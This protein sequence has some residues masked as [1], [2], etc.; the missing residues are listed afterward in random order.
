VAGATAIEAV[1][2]VAGQRRRAAMPNATC[3]ICRT[4]P[5]G[6]HADLSHWAGHHI[7]GVKDRAS[8]TRGAHNKYDVFVDDSIAVIINAVADFRP[9]ASRRTAVV[10]DSIAVIVQSI[11]A[12]FQHGWCDFARTRRPHSCAAS[13][14][15]PGTNAH[16]LGTRWARV[17]GVQDPIDGTIAVVVEVVA[18]L[19]RRENLSRTIRP[20]LCGGEDTRDIVSALS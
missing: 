18:N 7:A 6:L 19:G 20:T 17:A 16:T 3:W 15:S 9:S 12:R 5:G 2:E 8:H 14:Y 1:A 13:T 11:T 4:I 10:D